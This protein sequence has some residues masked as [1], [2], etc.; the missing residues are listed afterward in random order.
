[1]PPKIPNFQGLDHLAGVVDGAFAR[2]GDRDGGENQNFGRI[3]YQ[4][5]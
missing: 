2:V 5:I 1:M 4:Y 3:K